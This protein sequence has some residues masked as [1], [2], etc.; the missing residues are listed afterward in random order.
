MTTKI[1][2]FFTI[3]LLVCSA[4]L[5]DSCKD[6]RMGLVTSG[7]AVWVSGDSHTHTKYSDGTGTIFQNFEQAKKQGIDYVTITD[8]SN[9]KGWDEA[10]AAGLQYGIIPIRGNEYSHSTYSHALFI[11]V[12]QEKN[13]STLDPP[14]AVRTLKDDTNGKGLVYVAHPFDDGIDHWQET[15]GWESPIDGIEVW[16]AWYA[17]RYVVNARAFEKWDV[18][19][20]QGRHLYGIATTDTHSSRYV[21]E[22]YTTVFVMEYTA[23]GILNG[24]RAGR[25]YGSNGPIVDFRQGGAMMGDDVGVAKDGETVTFEISGKYCRPLSKV[26]LVMN[27]EVVYTK[28]INA[29]TFA[30]NVEMRVK[31]GD[32]V[33]MEVEGQETDTRKLNGS[34][35]DTSAP[36]AFTNPIFFIEK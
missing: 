19:N 2:H 14:D 32:F 5:I 31:P 4:F 27:G 20:K 3:I 25:M 1:I 24:H 16:N 26:L 35:F 11:N 7:K 10:Q 17:G 6:A 13:Y 36:F 33:R 18:L 29:R 15:K 8:H 34:S 23:E 9:S 22:A 30:E 21:G 12:N 28:E